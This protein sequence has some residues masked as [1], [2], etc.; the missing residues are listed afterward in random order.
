MRSLPR[1]GTYTTR[2]VFEA[3]SWRENPAST[4]GRDDYGRRVDPSLPSDRILRRHAAGL[5]R[6]TRLKAFEKWLWSENPQ[7]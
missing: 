2:I 1:L 5:S 3:C 4:K 7:I 6:W